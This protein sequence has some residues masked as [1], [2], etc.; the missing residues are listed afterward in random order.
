[1]KKGVKLLEEVVGHGKEVERQKYYQIQLRCWLNKGEAIKW[2]HPGGRVD[3]S[4]LLEDGELLITEVRINRA[5]IIS[6]LF[7]GV[8]GMKIGGTRK[9]KISPHLAYGEKG[10]PGIIPENATLVCEIKIV[11]ECQAAIKSLEPV[12]MERLFVYGTLAPGQANHSVLASIPGT[13]ET[14]VIRG[15]LLDKGWGSEMGCP[16]IVPSEEGEEVNGYVLASEHLSEH[17][18]MLDKFEGTGYK[19]QLA[20]V[21]IDSGDLVNAYVYALNHVD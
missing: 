2:K 4:Q 18:E 8:E 11:Q 15:K 9:L 20:R 6:G 3:R 16:G 7:Y 12:T 14:A 21:K 1:M 17:W 5:Q 10:L 13:W 19:R